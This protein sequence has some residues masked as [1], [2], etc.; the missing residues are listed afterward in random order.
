MDY[1]AMFIGV[2]L[3]AVGA[4]VGLVFGYAFGQRSILKRIGRRES[5]HLSPFYAERVTKNLL[6][7][8]ILE[9]K[10]CRF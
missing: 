10:E 3:V 7:A 6:D 1:F 2:C 8:E 5:K 9:V 4:M